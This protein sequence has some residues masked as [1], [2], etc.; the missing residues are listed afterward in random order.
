MQKTVRFFCAVIMA[1][2]CAVLGLLCFET[3]HTSSSYWVTEDRSLVI[4]D[5]VTV[6]PVH[7]ESMETALPLA[8]ETGTVSLKL[9]GLIPIREATVTVTQRTLVVPCGTPFGIKLYTDGVIVVGFSDVD[10]VTGQENP[11]KSA[12]LKT[13]DIIISVNGKSVTTTAAL[14]DC[15]ETSGGKTVLLRVRRNGTEFTTQLYPA[16]SVSE[17]RYKAGLWVRDSAAGIGTLTFYNPQDSSFAGLGHAMCDVDTGKLMPLSSGEIVPARIYGVKKGVSGTPGGL[18][19]GFENGVLGT[20]YANTQQ[21]VYGTVSHAPSSNT[22]IPLA[23]KQDVKEGEA[24]ILTTI[25][26]IKPRYYT[27]RIKKVSR[28]NSPDAHDLVIEIT[29]ERLLN[30][31]GGIVQGM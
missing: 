1:C 20:L 12:G 3:Y 29:D 6:S 31:T 25:D 15:I 8:S 11:A 19:G 10:T 16:C 4:D 18:L 30:A 26:G 13:G 24:L 28:S 17:T 23:M 21:G 27:A 5:M 22:A 2:M 7:K 14:S 9:F